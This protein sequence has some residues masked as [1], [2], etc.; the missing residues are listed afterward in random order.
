[1]MKLVS[2]FADL[3]CRILCFSF[4]AM[5]PNFGNS[6]FGECRLVIFSD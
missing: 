2:N 4:I 1:M 5:T 6:D 3:L